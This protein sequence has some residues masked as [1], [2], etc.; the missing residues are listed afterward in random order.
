MLS[1]LHKLSAIFFYVLGS[2]VFIA[3]ILAHN[4]IAVGVMSRWLE[5]VDLPLLL[6][7]MLYGGISIYES[8]RTDAS[9]PKVM[10]IAIG[11]PLLILFGVILLLNF[12]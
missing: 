3:Y 10:T 11:L 4:L 9:S 5:V 6:S 12:R 7:G 8:L 2:S 1:Y